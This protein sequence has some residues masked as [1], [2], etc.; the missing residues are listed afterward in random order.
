MG[1]LLNVDVFSE[2]C[3]CNDPAE[4]FSLVNESWWIR[5]EIGKKLRNILKQT[6]NT[7]FIERRLIK[8]VCE[9]MRMRIII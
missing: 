7:L 5:V 2:L 4:Y 8:T 3:L 9:R 6:P 1:E